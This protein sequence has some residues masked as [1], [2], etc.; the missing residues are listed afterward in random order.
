VLPDEAMEML[1][2]T[3]SYA[4][5]KGT[6]GQA[7]VDLSNITGGLQRISQLATDFPQIEELNIN[8]FF[9]G[10][11]GTKAMVVDARISLRR[12]PQTQE[13][14]SGDSTESG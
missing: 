7:D 4:L 13:E 5:L 14:A 10:S 8:P 1:M 11:L 6:R 2:E 3:R 9:V 12:G